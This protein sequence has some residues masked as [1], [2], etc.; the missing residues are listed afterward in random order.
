MLG[1]GGGG[2]SL[3]DITQRR[4][5]HRLGSTLPPT[6]CLFKDLDQYTSTVR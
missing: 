4:L 6:A 2:G 3:L 1:Q 5:G